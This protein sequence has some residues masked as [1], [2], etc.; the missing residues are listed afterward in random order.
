MEVPESPNPQECNLL[1]S[2]LD[3]NTWQTNKI[4]IW[5]FIRVASS[6]FRSINMLSHKFPA[7][8][9][10]SI[11]THIPLIPTTLMLPP[12]NET[13]DLAKLITRIK[14]DHLWRLWQLFIHR[15]Q[16]RQAT[17]TAPVRRT[18]WT[19]TRSLLLLLFGF[20]WGGFVEVATLALKNNRFM[21]TVFFLKL[22]LFDVIWFI[23]SSLFIHASQTFQLLFLAVQL[24]PKSQ[25]QNSSFT[26]NLKFE[27][28]NMIK[29]KIKISAYLMPRDNTCILATIK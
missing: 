15:L 3:S 11:N 26:S 24:T 16:E 10:P 29:M 4:P 6:S 21:K 27:N 14:E 9:K 2:D 17:D 23:N 22:T 28:L 7:N 19:Y 18:P 5:R 13:F 8:K 25:F 20:G 1:F 12:S